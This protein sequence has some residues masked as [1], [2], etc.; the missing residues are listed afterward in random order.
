VVGQLEWEVI[1]GPAVTVGSTHSRR[2]RAQGGVG[3]HMS[4]ELSWCASRLVSDSVSFSGKL[5][6]AADIFPRSNHSIDVSEIILGLA[7]IDAPFSTCIFVSVVGHT[8]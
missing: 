7:T 1:V 3:A 6:I 5:K 8:L 4:A 2:T